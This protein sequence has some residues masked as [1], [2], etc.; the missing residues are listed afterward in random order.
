MSDVELARIRGH[1]AEGKARAALSELRGLGENVVL[2]DP[3]LL[4][5]RV[6]AHLEAGDEMRAA[7]DLLRLLDTTGLAKLPEDV[8]PGGLSGLLSAFGPEGKRTLGGALGKWA[9]ARQI[10][11]ADAET[12]LASF[13]HSDWPLDLLIASVERAESRGELDAVARAKLQ[14][15]QRTAPANARVA[16]LQKRIVGTPEQIARRLKDEAKRMRDATPVH[17]DRLGADLG[18]EIPSPLLLAWSRATGAASARKTARKRGASTIA[19]VEFLPMTNGGV[20]QSKSLAKDLA[21][22]APDTKLV[23]FAHLDGDVL[24]LDVSRPRP[25]DADF[26]V[27]RLGKKI[28]VLAASTSDWLG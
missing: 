18:V 27:L 13:P 24:A 10:P 16:A 3:R 7:H 20:A 22:R 1:L 26:P 19:K 9:H 5:C 23:P 17:P 15:L 21:A 6:W 4:A 25:G 8:G 2:R 14:H 11:I 12:I 28:E